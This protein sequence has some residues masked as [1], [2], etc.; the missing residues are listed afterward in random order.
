MRLLCVLFNVMYA[1]V[2]YNS[3]AHSEMTSL[4]TMMFMGMAAWNWMT[5]FNERGGKK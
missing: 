1:H 3:D 4:F 5:F 2:S